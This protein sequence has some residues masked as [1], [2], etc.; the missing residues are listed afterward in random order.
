MLHS[1]G[2][3]MDIMDDILGSGVTI[4]NPQDLCNGIDDL[5]RKVK[6]RV[7]IN[8]DVDRQSIVPFGSPK[9]IREL[10]EEEVRT[11][12]SPEGGLEFVCGIYPPTPPKNVDAVCSAMEEFRTYWVTP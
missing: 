8:L 4:I 6:G 10:I 1:D 12:G 11:L 2:Y 7:C 5:A 3:L 9:E